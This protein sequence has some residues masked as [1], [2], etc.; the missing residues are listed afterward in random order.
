MRS[1]PLGLL[2]LNVNW[3][4]FSSRKRVKPLHWSK[5]LPS[6]AYC[7]LLV[8]NTHCWRKTLNSAQTWTLQYFFPKLYWFVAEG[9]LNQSL[10]I[11]STMSMSTVSQFFSLKSFYN[12]K[13]LCW[14]MFLFQPEVPKENH[15]SLVFWRF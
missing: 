14:N 8:A 2:F 3:K 15:A 11:F 1:T 13:I 12:E 5:S 6:P 7:F 10:K 4:N 9:F